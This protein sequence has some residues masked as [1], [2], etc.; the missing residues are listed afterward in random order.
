M[1][2]INESEYITAS[3]AQM[4][5]EW[6]AKTGSKAREMTWVETGKGEHEVQKGERERSR[7]QSR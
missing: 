1:L 4:F 2:A 3:Y 5:A 6:R 7:N